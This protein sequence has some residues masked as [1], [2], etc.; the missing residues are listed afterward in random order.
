MYDPSTLDYAMVN[1]KCKSKD[2]FTSYV[3][4]GFVTCQV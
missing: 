1:T 3:R 2:L 4:T